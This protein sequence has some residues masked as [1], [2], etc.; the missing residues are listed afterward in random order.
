[1]SEIVVDSCVVAKWVIPE[2][3]SAK[4]YQLFTD[5]TANGDQLVMLD[6]A[7]AEV[8][9]A[10]WKRQRLR[11]ITPDEAQDFL[12]TLGS[13]PTRIEPAATLLSEAYKI[14]VKY[15][16]SVYDALFVSLAEKLNVR[17]ITSDEPLFNATHRDF[18]R[19]QLLRNL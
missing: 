11:L 12:D 18:P 15:D 16:R 14:A 9:N 17:G 2:P 5:A 3:D 4:A 19:V 8:A 13:L 6:L 10:I 1:M 7:F